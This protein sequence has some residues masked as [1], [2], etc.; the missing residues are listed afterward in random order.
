MKIIAFAAS[1]SRQSINKKLV[2]YATSLLDTADIEILDLNDFDMPLFSQDREAELGQHPV[3]Q[4]FLDKI[5]S[6]DGLVI[7]FAEHNGSYSAAY[8]NVFD[9]A[10]RISPKVYAD[11]KVVLLSTSPGPGGAGNVL[12]AAKNSMPYFGATVLATQSVPSFYDNFDMAQNVLTHPELVAQVK[13]AVLA[14][15]A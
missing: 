3:A 8:K 11:K 13:A 6:A 2:Q 14:L 12:A 4:S 7:S 5:S 9:W 1:S 10:S 15:Q